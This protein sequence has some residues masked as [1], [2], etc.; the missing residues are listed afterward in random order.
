[1]CN[2][3]TNMFVCNFKKDICVW[4]SN[5]HLCVIWKKK[6][7]TRHFKRRV[8]F[9]KD[10]CVFHII[11]SGDVHS[12]W[13]I[14]PM[15]FQTCVLSVTVV[16]VSNIPSMLAWPLLLKGDKSVGIMCAEF[17]LAF[18]HV[19]NFSPKSR[20]QDQFFSPIPRK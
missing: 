13:C 18:F 9:Q 7:F 2:L 4:I 19:W 15:Y 6:K 10:I 14:G 12:R 8:T 1:M 16:T 20:F 11:S 17:N 3:K 5:R